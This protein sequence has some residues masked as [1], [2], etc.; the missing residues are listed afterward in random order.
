MLK[1]MKLTVTFPPKAKKGAEYIAVPRREYKQFQKYQA[2]VKDALKKIERG[3]KA[4]R[5]GKTKKI[6]SLRELL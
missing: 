6:K 5:A 4:L 2:E 3:E 1:H